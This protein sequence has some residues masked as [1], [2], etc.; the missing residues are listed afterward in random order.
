MTE[1]LPPNTGNTIWNP[2][3]E[4]VQEQ[5]PLDEIGRNISVSPDAS[6]QVVQLGRIRIRT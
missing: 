4:N 2:E 6:T 1:D 3:R 5:A